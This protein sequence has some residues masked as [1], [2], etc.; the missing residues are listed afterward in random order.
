MDLVSADPDH[1]TNS[2][3][4]VSGNLQVV[5]VSSPEPTAGKITSY[6]VE[7]F[8]QSTDSLFDEGGGVEI[9][10]KATRKLRIESEVI[11]GGGSGNELFG[12]RISYSQPPNGF[13]T[14]LS[15]RYHPFSS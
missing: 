12:H 1:A 2:N 9:K 3:W 15:Y 10:T 8:V 7:P 5:T 13:R 14:T 4:I 11:C 6:S